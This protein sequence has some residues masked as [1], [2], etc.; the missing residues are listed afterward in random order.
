MLN[1]MAT[2]LL[3]AQRKHRRHFRTAMNVSRDL[4]VPTNLVVLIFIEPNRCFML[5]SEDATS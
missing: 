5:R 1:A 4:L 2:T 3:L